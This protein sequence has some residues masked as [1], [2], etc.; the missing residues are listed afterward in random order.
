MAGQVQTP[1][2]VGLVDLSWGVYSPTVFTYLCLLA[3]KISARRREVGGAVPVRNFSPPGY[4]TKVS[5]RTS[6][7]PTNLT[8]S[9]TPMSAG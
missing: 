4:L 9:S 3:R 2:G 8:A 1:K 6:V 7:P 5:P